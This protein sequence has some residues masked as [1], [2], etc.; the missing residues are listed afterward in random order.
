M[1]SQRVNMKQYSSAFILITVFFG[2]MLVM[3]GS[4]MAQEEKSSPP[5]DWTFN[6][7]I[8]EACSC[9]TFCQ[10]YFNT[11]PTAHHD[12]HGGEE[13]FC[14]FNQAYKVNQGHYGDIKLDGVKF[15]T[16][17]DAGEDF[18]EGKM[19][20]QVLTFDPSVTTAQR[21][22]IQVIL[23]QHLFPVEWNSSTVAKDAQ[24]DWQVTQD[25]AEARLDGG[26]VAEIVLRRLGGL[27]DEPV[28]IKNV[29]WG[30]EPRNDG[31]TLMPNEVEAYR[32]GEKAF[33]YKGTNG[34]MVTVDMTSEDVK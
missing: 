32:V 21:E 14:R 24:V 28:V 5:P 19:D 30:A 4:T 7:T 9:P 26:K 18:S 31:F 2:M 15:W 1:R 27:N 8:M 20:W 6:T 29:S 11:Q 3:A 12:G 34:F 23:R 17:G 13:R 25:G 10:C 33:E 22:A 16:A